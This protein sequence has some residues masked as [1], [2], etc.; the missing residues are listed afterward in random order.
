LKIKK[1]LLTLFDNINFEQF[2]EELVN[3]EVW[4]TITCS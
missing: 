3:R 1:K 2:Y 4:F